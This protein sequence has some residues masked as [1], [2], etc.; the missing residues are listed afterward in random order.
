[1]GDPHFSVTMPSPVGQLTLVATSHG[2]RAVLWPADEGRVALPDTIHEQ[3]SHPVLVETRRQLEEYFAGSRREFDIPL[4]LRGTE[5]QRAAWQA[6]A[7]I[8]YGTTAT[9]SE[10]ATRI[11]RPRA[12][13]AVGAANGRNPVSIVLPCH[14][15][16]GRDGSLTGFAGGLESK[17][18]LLHL[19]GAID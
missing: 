7:G 6:L 9:Y 18:I 4:D 2:L 3:P 1:M 16:V 15:V 8:P 13:R 17:R 11:G 12:V 10:Q 14:R 19:E 5:F